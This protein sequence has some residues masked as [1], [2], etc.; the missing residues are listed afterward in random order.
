MATLNIPNTFVNGTAAVATE[1]NANFTEVKTFVESI[2]AGTNIDVN[3]ITET[4]ILNQNVTYSK[5][6]AGVTDLIAIGNDQT[7]LSTQVF[8]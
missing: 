1:V 4:K 8:A 6:A 3:A 5:L 7:I 2:A